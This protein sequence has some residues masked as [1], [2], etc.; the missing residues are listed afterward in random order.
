MLSLRSPPDELDLSNKS[1]VPHIS[2]VFREM[3]DSTGL[4]GSPPRDPLKLKG[5]KYTAVESHIS[6]KT[7]EMWGTRRSLVR[8]KFVG[9][10]RDKVFGLGLGQSFRSWGR[11]K[12]FGLGVGTKFAVLGSGQSLRSWVRTEFAVLGR[13]KDF[14]VLGRDKVCGL[15]DQPDSKIRFA[16]CVVSP[17]RIR[18]MACGTLR[19][20]IT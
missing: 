20:K 19:L 7:S 12:V 8:T 11:D 10:G 2:L 9:I 18:P 1:W 14:E 15:H 17:V 3:W 13:D 6:R 5:Y 16:Y 4:N